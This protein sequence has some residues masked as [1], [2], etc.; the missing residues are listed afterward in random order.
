MTPHPETTYL[1]GQEVVWTGLSHQF[2]RLVRIMEGRRSY[3]AIFGETP[4]DAEVVYDI[5]DPVTGG[6]VFGIP[7]GQLH[8]AGLK[9]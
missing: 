4:E 3:L 7:A 5:A 6:T 9:E 8:P 2:E 1:P